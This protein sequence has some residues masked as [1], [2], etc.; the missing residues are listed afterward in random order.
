[1]K[2]KKNST[3]IVSKSRG[4]DAIKAYTITLS[5]SIL[6]I[7]FNGLKTLKALRPDKF[8]LPP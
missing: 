7:D 3:M 6:E 8:K 1:M 2:K 5:P 4:I